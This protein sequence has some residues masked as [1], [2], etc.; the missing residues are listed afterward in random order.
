MPRGG[1]I[2][3]PQWT[4]ADEQLLESLHRLGH[5]T[6]EIAAQMG[7]SPASVREKRRCML[8]GR[9]WNGP[10]M[11]RSRSDLDGPA[12]VC[13]HRK[14]VKDTAAS[15]EALGEALLA[16]GYPMV[17]AKPEHM[18]TARRYT[19]VSHVPGASSLE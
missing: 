13:E 1:S 4:Y 10:N 18:P 5:N 2:A 3:R 7:R 15:C 14:W 9:M 12:E 16:A 6:N 19:P 17:T 11:S 8:R